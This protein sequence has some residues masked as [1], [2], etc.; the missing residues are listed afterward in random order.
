MKVIRGIYNCNPFNIRFAKSNNWKGQIG[1]DEKRFCRFESMHCGIRAG[2][3]LLRNYIEKNKLTDVPSIIKRFAPH[4]ENNTSAYIRYCSNVLV[5]QGLPTSDLSFD[6]LAF[7]TLCV[8]IL[9]YES[10]Y[11]AHVE[12]IQDI[13][14]RFN[15]KSTLHYEQSFLEEGR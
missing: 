8:A 4:T 11:V 14:S 6:S 13:K 15:I 5:N 12:D 9:Y 7:D 10:K 2:I 1:S 3:I